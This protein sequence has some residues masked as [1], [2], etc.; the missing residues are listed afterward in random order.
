[1]ETSLKSIFGT[2]D[3][4]VIRV[5]TVLVA[6]RI[7]IMVILCALAS[8]LGLGAHELLSRQEF[9]CFDENLEAA[10]FQVANGFQDGLR[11]LNFAHRMAF[12]IHRSAKLEGKVGIMPFVTLPG[13]FLYVES[14]PRIR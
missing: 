1:M 10:A 7:V 14:K 2:K 4:E 3:P 11:R 12:S 13:Q 5:R 6:I 9:R 8:G